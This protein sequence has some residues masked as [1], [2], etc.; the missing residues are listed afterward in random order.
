YNRL[1]Q[2]SG[3]FGE[4]LVQRFRGQQRFATRHV[5]VVSFK[6]LQA[7]ASWVALRDSEDRRPRRAAGAM[8]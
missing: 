7:R 8:P 4:A 1:G 2:V 6:N 3:L 5:S